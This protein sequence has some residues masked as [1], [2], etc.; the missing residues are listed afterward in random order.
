MKPPVL[1]SRGE[2]SHDLIVRAAFIHISRKRAYMLSDL[3]GSIC[4]VPAGTFIGLTSKA[5]RT[6]RGLRNNS[7]S[8]GDA[9][10]RKCRWEKQQLSNSS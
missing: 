8:G 9:E 3:L 4:L 2:K 5:I 10:L 7:S 1:Q 6:T